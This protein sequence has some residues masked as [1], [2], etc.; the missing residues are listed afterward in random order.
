MEIIKQ[1]VLYPPPS[2]GGGF[3]LSAHSSCSVP[4]LSAAPPRHQLT[5]VS[6]VIVFVRISTVHPSMISH[7]SYRFSS[8]RRSPIH[9]AVPEE[10]SRT[11]F[12]DHNPLTIHPISNADSFQSINMIQYA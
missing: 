3:L 11:A 9:S 2:Y 1:R 8:I 12:V 10:A 5:D 4:G 7:W 6:P